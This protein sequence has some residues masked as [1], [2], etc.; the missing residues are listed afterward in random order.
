MGLINK[1]TMLLGG[2]AVAAVAGALKNRERVAGL[3]GVR[4]SGAEPP[5]PADADYAAPEQ[6]RTPVPTEPAPAPEPSNYDIGGPAANTS[7]S[8]PAPEP[9]VTGRGG[10]DEAAEEAAAAAE[11]AGIG[12][13]VADYAGT[14]LG[15]PADEA[16]RP[17]MEAGE[18]AAEGQEQAEAM[19]QDN[20]EPA[21][22]DPI[23][24]QR[25]IEDVIEAAGAADRGE[26]LEGIQTE[27]PRGET[28]GLG[29]QPAVRGTGAPSATSGATS[30]YSSSEAERAE[31]RATEPADAGEAATGSGSEPAGAT[32]PETSVGGGDSRAAGPERAAGDPDPGPETGK[33]PDQGVTEPGATTRDDVPREPAETAPAEEGGPSG[34]ATTGPAG[35]DQASFFSP[36]AEGDPD[37]QRP[38]E[39]PPE[40]K[41]SAVWAPPESGGQ[42]NEDDD[43][44]Q[45]WSG[46][47]SDS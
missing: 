34:D 31:G 40:Q 25:Q 8:V 43:E 44:W 10:I 36:E 37:E 27:P 1:R 28:S 35:G 20:A 23:H 42:K 41:S 4:S 46:R 26:E 39:T 5:A 11:A 30:A 45:T 19:L 47:A 29:S 6:T 16:E 21:A 2:L 24:G 14:E 3:I 12:G 33:V 7:T 22:G 17:L 32:G 18:G 38:T 13:P 15:E 9:Q